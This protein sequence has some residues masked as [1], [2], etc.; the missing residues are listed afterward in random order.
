MHDICY[1]KLLGLVSER[2]SNNLTLMTIMLFDYLLAWGLFYDVIRLLY[3]LDRHTLEIYIQVYM[4]T[5]KSLRSQ[6]R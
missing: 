4:N 3:G 1:Q 6:I 5:Y 2:P